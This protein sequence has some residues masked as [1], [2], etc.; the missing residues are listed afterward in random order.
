MSPQMKR[1]EIFASEHLSPQHFRA[2]GNLPTK[3][4]QKNYITCMH[5]KD[6]KPSHI[7]WICDLMPPNKMH[8]FLIHRR[9]PK[10]VSHQFVHLI[11]N[12]GRKFMA[13]HSILGNGSHCCL[14]E[15]K[16]PGWRK[17]FGFLA[18]QLSLDS[19]HNIMKFITSPS[20]VD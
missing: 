6:P 12:L 10:K 14:N 16:P 4:C 8:F 11:T 3:L 18:I 7:G 20:L 17:T 9:A 13:L 5:I 1:G 2:R 19:F 15:H